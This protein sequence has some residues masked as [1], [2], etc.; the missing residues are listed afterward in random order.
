MFPHG[1]LG[2]DNL[3]GSAA[4][5]NNALSGECVESRRAI[6]YRIRASAKF[7]WRNRGGSRHQGEGVTRDLC[8]EGMYILSETCPPLDAKL[9]I[10]VQFPPRGKG[11][12]LQMRTSG[13]VVRRE[14]IA[15]GEIRDG[16]AAVCKTFALRIEKGEV[17]N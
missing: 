2:F 17:V 6:R 16:F 1:G 11:R 5:A 15:E 13:S 12:G 14:L 10:Q 8:T 9:Q 7:R 4:L 3:Y